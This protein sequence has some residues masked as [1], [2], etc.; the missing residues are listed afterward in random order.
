MIAAVKRYFRRGSQVVLEPAN[1]DFT[2]ILVDQYD[3]F[4]VLGRVAGL[5]RRFSDKPVAALAG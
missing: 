5:F 1:P 3:D 4:A 2:P